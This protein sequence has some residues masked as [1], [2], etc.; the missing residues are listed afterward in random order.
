MSVLLLLVILAVVFNGMLGGASLEASLVK[1]PARKR[2]GA[3][4]YAVFARGNDLGNGLWVYPPWA[5]ISA[6]LVFAATITSLAGGSAVRVNAA[7]LAAS[8]T[9]VLHFIATSQAA[10][11]MLSIGHA[12]D[13]EQLLAAKLDRFALWHGVRAVFQVLTFLILVRV[14]LLVR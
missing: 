7:L 12:P 2:I 9:S 1:L 10:P 14:L 4:A 3:L 6:L 13:D 5:I 8:A 11:V